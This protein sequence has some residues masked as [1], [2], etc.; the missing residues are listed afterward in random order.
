M[1]G[2]NSTRYT[3]SHLKPRLD[4]QGLFLPRSRDSPLNPFVDILP[5]DQRLKTSHCNVSCPKEIIIRR[6]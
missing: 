6:V 4:E 3:T 2:G 5:S 1:E